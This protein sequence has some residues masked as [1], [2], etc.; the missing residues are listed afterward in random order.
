MGTLREYGRAYYFWRIDQLPPGE[1]RDLVQ[2]LHELDGEAQIPLARKILNKGPLLSWCMVFTLAR[3]TETLSRWGV[4][5][6]FVRLA[7]LMR[8]RALQ[9]LSRPSSANGDDYIS[10]LMA[11]Q[12]APR[13]RDLPL[14]IQCAEAY[15]HHESLLAEMAQIFQAV[16]LKGG[17]R[18]APELLAFLKKEFSRE[19]LPTETIRPYTFALLLQDHEETTQFIWELAEHIPFFPKGM[20]VLGALLHH[21]PQAAIPLAERR[22]KAF[23]EQVD[24]NTSAQEYQPFEDNFTRALSYAQSD[25]HEQIQ[26]QGQLQKLLQML[27]NGTF[28]QKQFREATQAF[29]DSYYELEELLRTIDAHLG[30]HDPQVHRALLRLCSNLRLQNSAARTVLHEK[31][32]T[33]FEQEPVLVGRILINMTDK[34]ETS[35][36]IKMLRTYFQKASQEHPQIAL[37]LLEPLFWHDTGNFQVLTAGLQSLRTELRRKTVELL[38]YTQ[39]PPKDY[40]KIIQPI[41]DQEQD[42]ELKQQLIA[43][44]KRLKKWYRSQS[45]AK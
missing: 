11:L 2:E 39:N 19:D 45:H 35:P 3:Y 7:G 4:T 42:Q 10:A 31:V 33:Y 38:D 27:G 40:D 30:Q 34:R 28:Q 20:L 12:F 25:L 43:Y 22:Y 36:D 5:N 44:I 9:I 32:T 23:Q 21:N 13:Y 37:G 41:I 15:P 1:W 18:P 6:H 17:G 24:E 29:H 16:A 8:R 14:L 26:E